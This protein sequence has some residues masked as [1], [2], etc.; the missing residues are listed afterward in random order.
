MSTKL[1]CKVCEKDAIASYWPTKEPLCLEH[2][3]E[4]MLA[5]AKKEIERHNVKSLLVAVSGGKDSKVLLDLLSHLNIRIVA[6]TIIEGIK[7][8]RRREAEEMKRFSKERGIDHLVFTLKE[9]VGLSVDEWYQRRKDVTP[10]TFCGVARRRALDL[11]SKQLGLEK[12]ATGHTLDD[13]IHTIVVNLLRGDWFSI[14][15]LREGRVKP[16]RKIYE[17]NVASYAFFKKFGFQAEEC[18]YILLKPSLRAK[19]RQKLYYLEAE[20]PGTFLSLSEWLDGLER[21]ER[22]SGKCRICGFPTSPN[23]DICK[24]C[25]LLLSVGFEPKYQLSLKERGGL[26]HG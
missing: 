21:L 15:K 18:P 24:L 1:K 23:R 6:V 10:C 20:R 9:V 2:L 19:I 5:Y 4:R 22:P 17:R 12:V 14:L 3:F 13:E 7:E 11:L 16:L 8:Y 25:E 26:A